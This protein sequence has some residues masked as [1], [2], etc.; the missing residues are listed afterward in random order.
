MLTLSQAAILEKN[1]L[2]SDGAYIILL[3]IIISS[4]LTLR[5]C[6]NTEDVT[7]KGQQWIAFPFDFGGDITHDSGGSLPQFSVKVSNVTRV[8]EGYLEQ[9]DGGV[10]STVNVYVVNVDAG[11]NVVDME[12]HE[13][14]IVKSVNYDVEWVNFT[15]TGAANLTRRVPERRFL[16]NACP[17]PYKGPECKAT[18]GYTTCDK[19]LGACRM[20][21][22]ALR[23][24][25]E[26]AIP[27]GGIHVSR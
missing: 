26:P 8:V 19:T 3:E 20:R 18:S 17:F 21:N 9:A 2:V 6:R 11:K 7:F 25:G 10:G 14:F 23:Y 12:L 1:K 15:L 24:G 22:N 27:Q 16:K 13:S 4:T 5:I